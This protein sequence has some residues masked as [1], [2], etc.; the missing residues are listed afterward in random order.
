MIIDCGTLWKERDIIVDV[1]IV[2][3]YSQKYFNTGNIEKYSIAF[4]SAALLSWW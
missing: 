4:S 2:P 1:E 3:R